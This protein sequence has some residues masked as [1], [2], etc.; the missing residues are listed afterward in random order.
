MKRS[1][2]EGWDK[3]VT[4]ITDLFKIPSE[5]VV[6]PLTAF[7]ARMDKLGFPRPCFIEKTQ[8]IEL[9]EDGFMLMPAAFGEYDEDR[10][11]LYWNPTD[12]RLYMYDI[13]GPFEVEH[14]LR[15]YEPVFDGLGVA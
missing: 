11:D 14:T 8:P 9:N 1:D 7:V 5:S 6:S 10:P 13:D 4:P 12:R 2:F 15:G 3:D